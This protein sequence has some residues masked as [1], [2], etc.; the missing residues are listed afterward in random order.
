MCECTTK[1]VQKGLVFFSSF[2]LYCHGLPVP[3]EKKN[4]KAIQI[5][6]SK[7]YGGLSVHFL[8]HCV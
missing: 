4:I 5:R 7:T 2:A 8:T 3:E 1:D 6:Y